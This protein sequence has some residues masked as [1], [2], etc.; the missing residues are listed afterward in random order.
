M[1]QCRRRCSAPAWR[2]P[3]VSAP[4]PAASHASPGATS[5]PFGYRRHGGENA[6]DIAA[7]LQAEMGAAVIE[8]I[9][10]DITAAPLGLFV[11]F[12]FGPGFHHAAAD[13]PGLDVE[14]GFS[15]GFGE[16]K[17][18]F[19]I[20]AVMV[21]EED[22]ADTARLTAMRQPE[23]GVG[24]FLVF[25][26]PV[27]VEAIA[28]LLQPGMEIHRVGMA[29][30]ARGIESWIEIGA[31]AEPVFGGDD[32]A[33]VHVHRR[34]PRILHVSDQA[35]AAGPEAGIL[36]RAFDLLGEVGRE[37]AEYGGG[38]HADFLEQPAA[39]HTHHAAA[40]V[41]AARPGRL[42]E[43][44]RRARI[45][46][47]WR[48]V[49]QRFERRHDAIAQLFKPG[50]GL[51]F[52][53]LDHGGLLAG[54]A[55]PHHC[56]CGRTPPSSPPKRRL[57]RVGR[58][59]KRFVSVPLWLLLSTTAWAVDHPGQHFELKVSDLPKPYATPAVANNDT[60]IPR[61]A[62]MKP[63][64]P[65]GFTVS[66]FAD[67]LDNA[68]GLLT[69]PN[70]DVFLAERSPGKI[71]ILRDSKGKGAADQRFTFVTGLT[72][73]QGMALKNGYFYF[74]DQ[75]AVWRVSYKPGQTKAG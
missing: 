40:F 5:P 75:M 34:H 18:A 38:V 23:I 26:E 64:A 8:Q 2:R 60:D 30:T 6:F 19:P 46:L 12:L 45:K 52:A 21:I 11:A 4:A 51:R 44:A 66:I 58:V 37:G 17:V 65:K 43:T 20:A 73:P 9:E 31:A 29:R 3:G 13:D 74:S 41:L 69:A 28:G 71:T 39:H 47:G 61:P 70:G 42:F 22:A 27:L 63:Q 57:N 24:P 10:F 1:P 62:G 16:G 36:A 14:K 54:K 48:L 35:D 32:H 55:R 72:K 50:T 68:R 53:G 67:H 33:G 25:G 59:M 15:N 56:F 49:F 7:G